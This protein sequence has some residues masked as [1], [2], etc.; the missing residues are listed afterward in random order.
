MTQVLLLS[1]HAEFGKTSTA[2]ILKRYFEKNN[3]KVCIIPYAKYLKFIAKEYFNWD[4]NKDIKGRDLLIDLGTNIVRSK[5]KNFWVD[6]VINF[7]E[8]FN[9]FFDVFI[10]DDCRYPNEIEE[11]NNHNIPVVT[12]RII[13]KNFESCLTQE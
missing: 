13:R 1:G 11:W 9:D 10:I 4:G 12:V 2:N 5:N 6:A 8:V 7:F 3:K